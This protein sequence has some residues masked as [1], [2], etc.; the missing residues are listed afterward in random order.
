MYVY[1]I[2][3]IDHTIYNKQYVYIADMILSIIAQYNTLQHVQSNVQCKA[4]QTTREKSWNLATCHT[5]IH[6]IYG[7]VREG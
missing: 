1:T 5:D 4:L 2:I 6:P 3:I 7:Y